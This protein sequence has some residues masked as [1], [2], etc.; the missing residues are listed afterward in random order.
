M[1]AVVKTIDAD[2]RQRSPVP[3]ANDVAR[4]AAFGAA[5]VLA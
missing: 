2:R 5:G 1:A 4:K 3:G